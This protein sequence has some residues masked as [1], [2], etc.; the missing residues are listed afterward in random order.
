VYTIILIW[1]LIWLLETTH[2][3]LFQSLRNNTT[4]EIVSELLLVCELS[5]FI[6]NNPHVIHVIHVIAYTE[7][8]CLSVPCMLSQECVSEHDQKFSLFL[9]PPAY[10][11]H[12]VRLV[13]RSSTR[14]CRLTAG[15]RLF[16]KSVGRFLTRPDSG[17]SGHFAASCTDWWSIN[18]SSRLLSSVFCS[19]PCHS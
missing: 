3:A 4:T 19:V 16:I 7:C 2:Q 6:F 11:L 17:S 1:S 5:F 9:S 8:N 15:A 14:R 13:Y 12:P 18:T 10:R